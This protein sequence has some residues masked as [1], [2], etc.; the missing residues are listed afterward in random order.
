MPAR[1]R[2]LAPA[3]AAPAWERTRTSALP[4]SGSEGWRAAPRQERSGDERAGTPPAPAAL[5][6]PDGFNGGRAGAVGAPPAGAGEGGLLSHPSA[7]TSLNPSRTCRKAW[8]EGPDVRPPFAGQVPG[9]A[10]GRG[11]SAAPRSRV[12]SPARQPAAS[13][14]SAHHPRR[15]GRQRW[16]RLE[17]RCR[18]RACGAVGA[19]WERARGQRLPRHN[20]FLW[21]R[22]CW[23]GCCWPGGSSLP[24]AEGWERSC[25]FL[26]LQ[27]ARIQGVSASHAA[28]T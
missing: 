21:P 2:A 3:R 19:R 12:R 24:R 9:S 10:L 6:F 20:D 16:L 23:A 13:L 22:R 7:G 26:T 14:S 1:S 8:A 15:A 4:T 17:A 11:G 28:K 27:E 25:A 18:R 5:R